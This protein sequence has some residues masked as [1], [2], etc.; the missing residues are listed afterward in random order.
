MPKMAIF[1]GS[2]SLVLVL[3]LLGT[4]TYLESKQQFHGKYI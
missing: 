2:Q 3:E 4:Y 1:I